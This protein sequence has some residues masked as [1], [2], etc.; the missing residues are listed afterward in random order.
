[1]VECEV[2]TKDGYKIEYAY[3]P[4][5]FL[6]IL[7]DIKIKHT[8]KYLCEA[9]TFDIE[10]SNYYPFGEDGEPQ[11][12]MYHW[13]MCVNGYVIFGRRW[14]EFTNF[15]IELRDHFGLYDEYKAII[16]VHNL[17]FE[18]EF[19]REFIDLDECFFTEKRKPLKVANEYFE[20]RCSY[21]LSNMNLKKFIEDTEGTYHLKAS[22]DLDYS[23]L[24][25][26]DTELNL[27]ERGYCFNDVKG[28]HEAVNMLI[29]KERRIDNI[30]LTSTGYVRRD[31][32]KNMSKNGA[33]R[34]NFLKCKL[35][36]ELLTLCREAFRGGNTA[37]NRKHTN[38]KL[39][40]L[41]GEDITSSYPFQ[42]LTKYVPTGPFMKYTIENME[43]LTRL[44]SEYCTIG[45]Y[46]FNNI[47]LKEE[48]PIP[49]IAFS[50]CLKIKNEKCYNGRVLHADTLVI[51]LTEIDYRI[52]CNQYDFDELLI[53]QFY[54]AHAGYIPKELRRTVLEYFKLKSELK[55]NDEKKYEYMQSKG[56]LNSIYG[57][58]VS[59]ITH[60]T[61]YID[62]N[63]EYQSYAEPLNKQLDKYYNSWNSFLTYQWGLWITAHARDQLQEMID[64]IGN[65]VV[66]CDTDSI[67]FIGD[68]KADFDRMNENIITECQT[69]NVI[70][71]VTV[72]EKEYFTGLW[73][74][75]GKYDTFK[76]LG[77]KK[78][79]YEQ[80]GKIHVTVAGLNK[81]LG[82]AE[83]NE[84][85]GIDDFKIGKIFL[86]SGRTVAYYNNIGVHNINI[87]GCKFKSASNIAIVNTTYTLGITDTMLE[88]LNDYMD[89]DYEAYE[90]I[91]YG[92]FEDE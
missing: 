88:V 56:R 60:D 77:A 80:N 23:V 31:A 5:E 69:K 85:N 66:Y 34:A 82:A 90:N 48:V 37:S 79:C 14:E 53:G 30:P 51:S 29:S 61:F 42:M 81:K 70:H 19:M 45:R 10:T 57:M 40:N 2:L 11:A 28:L 36:P 17:A 8:K 55:G 59:N 35:T 78:Y 71:S 26:P 49:Y 43:Q 76:T 73:D 62:K 21:R 3:G 84:G 32:R 64:I 41:Q 86:K 15:L 58:C 9:F 47:K 83:L 6:A 12:F 65:D 63:G 68:H 91:L 20:F 87:N 92:G 89:I 16:Y 46:C 38:K 74:Y 33:N 52:I 4:V 13:Q 1:M 75:E 67:K 24:R 50:K 18:F 25:T 54:I 27:K 22:D 44:N 72:N 7:K 39:Y